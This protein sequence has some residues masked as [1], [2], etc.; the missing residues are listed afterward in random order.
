MQ[1]NEGGLN[2]YVTSWLGIAFDTRY[3]RNFVGGGG[4]VKTRNKTYAA[5]V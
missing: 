1:K 4:R 2:G 3:W 5:A